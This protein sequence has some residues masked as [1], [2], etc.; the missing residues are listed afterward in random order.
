[1]KDLFPNAEHRHCV[2]HMYT[3]FRGKHPGKE[4]KDIIWKAARA[5]YPQRFTKAMDELESKSKE[6]RVWFHHPDR[7]IGSWTKAFFSERALSV[8]YC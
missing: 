7:P 5:T 3:N 2:R 8:I 4:L 6:A 1:M